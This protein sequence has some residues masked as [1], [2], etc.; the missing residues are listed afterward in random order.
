MIKE[1]NKFN[2]YKE[3]NNIDLKTYKEKLEYTIKT[4]NNLLKN[5]NDAQIKIINQLNE[6]NLKES[7]N[8]V[9]ILAERVMEL[10]LE[11]SKHSLDLI[12]KT[13]E[14]KEQMAKIK[15]MKGELLNEFYN[16]IDD[17]K[18]ETNK[19][20]NSF[21]EF[22]NEY[23][24]IRKKFLELAEFIKDI[25]FKKN[26]G[27]DVNKKEINDLYKNL[28]KK[29]KKSHKDKNVQLITDIA[30]IKKMEFNNNK[31]NNINNKIK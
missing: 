24:V 2:N 17:F 29:T 14:I 1:I 5:N 28:V 18:L 20:V 4:F 3:K 31:T 23:A 25:R 15:E 27:A 9:D 13:N 26:L 21:N 11:N 30:K 7:K 6:K 19:T 16:K 8:M 10:R 22:K 12:S